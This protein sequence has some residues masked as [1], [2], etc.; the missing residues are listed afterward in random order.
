[1]LALAAVWSTAAAPRRLYD[2]PTMAGSAPR[3][4]GL[5][6]GGEHSCGVT[7]GGAGQCWGLDTDG[8]VSGL[9]TGVS[10]WAIL[11]AGESHTCGIATNG[12]AHCWGSDVWGQVSGLPA[13][14][15]WMSISAGV[16]HTCGVTTLG[17][18]YC[19]GTNS[20]GQTDVPSHS[21]DQPT[22]FQMHV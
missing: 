21:L 10:S 2:A 1:M 4:G 20:A 7:E 6:A 17:A 22:E 13:D 16:Y 14:L 9:P 19:W 15:K 12:D 3:Q 5:S 11:S 8:Q 18:G